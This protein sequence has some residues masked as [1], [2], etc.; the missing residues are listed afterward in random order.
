MLRNEKSVFSLCQRIY[1]VL[2]QNYF[3]NRSLSDREW[4]KKRTRL[5]PYP[6]CHFLGLTE[7]WQ[8]KLS[9]TDP[10]SQA[11]LCEDTYLGVQHRSL[12]EEPSQ[13]NVMPEKGGREGDGTTDL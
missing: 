12:Q 10:C 4:V 5:P 7:R 1:F 13:S 6:G 11:K 9:C 8:S 2:L 3:K